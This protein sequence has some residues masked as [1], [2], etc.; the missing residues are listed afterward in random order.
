MHAG[1]VASDPG[2]TRVLLI[3]PMN[4]LRCAL[5]KVLA[6]EADVQVVA[7][8]G[9]HD[10]LGAVRP[11]PRPNAAGRG[12]QPPTARRLHANCLLPAYP[13][14]CPGS[15]PRPVPATGSRRCTGPSAPAGS[16]FCP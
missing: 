4:L 13:T 1:V 15:S 8:L 16:N 3:E 11:T 12:L 5:A 6:G 14:T 7:E 10:D 9:G 2:P